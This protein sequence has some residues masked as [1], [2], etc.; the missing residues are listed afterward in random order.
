[1]LPWY[2]EHGLKSREIAVF[3]GSRPMIRLCTLVTFCLL[4]HA[5]TSWCWAQTGADWPFV[6]HDLR[7]TGRNPAIGNMTEPPVERW[8]YYLGGWNN[9]F[10]VT[11]ATGQSSKL[12]IRG[13]TDAQGLLP[14]KEIVWNSPQLVDLAGDAKLVS[15]PAG[16]GRQVA[17]RRPRPA[18]GGLGTSSGQADTWHWALL[19]I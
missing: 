7:L 16:Q 10:A 12:K 11:I 2:R 13:A 18:T 14:G 19:F 3:S 4:A 17:S 1:M 15:S 9:E 8:K 5:E 6:R